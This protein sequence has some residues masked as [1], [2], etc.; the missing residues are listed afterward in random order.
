VS[1]V[2]KVSR[3]LTDATLST[4]TNPKTESTLAIQG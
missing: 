4:T 3:G 2:L 1:N